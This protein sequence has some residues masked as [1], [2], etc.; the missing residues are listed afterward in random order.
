MLKRAF[1]SSRP[2]RSFPLTVVGILPVF[3]MI[4]L[5]A[6]SSASTTSVGPSPTD[7]TYGYFTP[8]VTATA[9]PTVATTGPSHVA[10]VVVSVNPGSFSNIAC[11]STATFTFTALINLSG[12]TG[13]TVNYT[14]STAG[15]ARNTGSVTFSAGQSSKSVT[16]TVTSAISPSSASAVSTVLSTS[17]NGTTFA[18]S[19]VTPSGTCV[20]TGPLRV[21]G[22]SMYVSPGSVSGY[23]CNVNEHMTYTATI[24]IAPDS[25]GGTVTVRWN[26]AVPVTVSISFPSY[27]TGVITRTISN[28]LVGKLSPGG[29]GFPAAVSMTSLAPDVVTSGAVRPA[30]SCV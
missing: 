28:S 15:S 26:F 14:W 7:P 10:G 5:T 30:G 21:T 3:L 13:G 22:I 20:Y 25:N 27:T 19:A 4:L 16:Y 11:G 29:R 9:K 6:C 24:T 23:P 12:N 17:L 1:R 8:T 18:S 2:T